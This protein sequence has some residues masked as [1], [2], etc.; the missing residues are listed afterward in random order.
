MHYD[1]STFKFWCYKVLP[2]VY[3]DSL[4]YYEVL[5]KVVDY[6]NK[7]IEQDKI[8]GNEVTELKNDFST[9]KEWVDNDELT[10]LK[11]DISI[12]QEWIDNYDTTYVKNLVEKLI[13]NMIYVD[14]SNSGYIIYHIPES[15]NDVKFYTTGLDIT[16]P[17]TNDYGHL[18]LSLFDNVQGTQEE[19]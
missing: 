12:V 18:V 8:F 15:W 19:N 14:I 5:C 4:S 17:T 2:L 3:D 10:K 7:L 13:A 1:L 16:V 6:I 9:V 11:N